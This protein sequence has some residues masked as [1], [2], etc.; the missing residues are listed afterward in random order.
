LTGEPSSGTKSE[1][2]AGG[3]LPAGVKE[4]CAAIYESDAAKLILGQSFHPGGVRL[5][6]RLGQILNLTPRTRVLDVAAGKGT[7]AIFLAER[8]GCEVVGIDYGRRNVEEADRTADD[9]GLREKVSFQRADAERLPFDDGSFDA[10]VCECAFCTFPNKQVAADEFAR[11]LRVGGQVGLSDLT[12]D[13]ALAPELDGL[14]SWIACIADAQPLT[15]YA[16]L[17]STAGLKVH[18]T[19]EHDAALTEFVDQIRLRLLAADVM[20]GLKK[21]VLPGFNFEAARNIAKHAQQAIT[22]G[23]L[24]Y[25][26]VTASKTME[27]APD[28]AV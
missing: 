27:G 19:E 18:V 8:F 20:V 12:R 9:R 21:L 15:S 16:A 26:I 10:I 13:G 11:I 25:A 17:L 28:K 6:E 23:K 14:L 22:M 5:T 7:S 4:C 2:A 24:G 1:I 3:D